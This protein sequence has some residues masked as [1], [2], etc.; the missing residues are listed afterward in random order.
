MV[1]FFE[2]DKISFREVY[3][4][5]GW[6]VFDAMPIYKVEVTA[7]SIADGIIMRYY[8]YANNDGSPYKARFY[9][10]LNNNFCEIC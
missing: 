2:K 5:I 6:S 7:F 1:K 10:G 3:E 8:R 4:Q 9:R